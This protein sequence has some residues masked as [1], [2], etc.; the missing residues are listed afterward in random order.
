MMT[1]NSEIPAG[2]LHNGQ[3]VDSWDI[4]GT[5]AGIP[6]HTT[7]PNGPCSLLP[8]LL[9][10]KVHDALGQWTPCKWD[11]ESTKCTPDTDST[12]G[13]YLNQTGFELAQKGTEAGLEK[14]QELGLPP[15]QALLSSCSVM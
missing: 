1:V 4:G 3:Q 10:T 11:S 13:K 2:Q 9:C 5:N 7:P 15:P 12:L 14:L 6:G 8:E